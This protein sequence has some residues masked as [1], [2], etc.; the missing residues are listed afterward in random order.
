[1]KPALGGADPG[2]AMK[3]NGKSFRLTLGLAAAAAML[4]PA[5]AGASNCPNADALPTQISIPAYNDAIHCLLDETRQSNG[6]RPLFSDDNLAAAAEGHSI[7]MKTESYFGHDSPDGG[8]FSDRI[9]GTGFMRGARRWLVGENI[10]WGSIALGTPQGLMT[11]WMNSPPH[12]ANILEATYREIG[13]ATVWGSPANPNM[14]AA[15]IVTTDF[16]YVKAK[17]KHLKKGRRTAS[18]RAR[19]G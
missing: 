7:S 13:V 12:R 4:I 9:A 16:G 19:A 5:S 1:L 10:A 3:V 14:P 11:G 18:R 17:G 6:L 15:A 8:A 2:S